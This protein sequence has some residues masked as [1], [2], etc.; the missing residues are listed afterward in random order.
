MS[1]FSFTHAFSTKVSEE[2]AHAL[3]TN[4]SDNS[5]NKHEP[6]AKG[7]IRTRA[8]HRKHYVY[9]MCLV[10]RS[11]S[12]PCKDSNIHHIQLT[13]AELSCCPVGGVMLPRAPKRRIFPKTGVSLMPHGLRQ[14][15]HNHFLQALGIG[16]APRYGSSQLPQDGNWHA[17]HH[18]ARC[19][20]SSRCLNELL[21]LRSVHFVHR[22]PQYLG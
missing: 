4:A 7:G 11:S 2:V 14:F 8:C 20:E 15:A 5:Y 3:S 19:P 22:G 12:Y 16:F 17:I 21:H 1:C 6:T 10:F 13:I 18:A 9:Y